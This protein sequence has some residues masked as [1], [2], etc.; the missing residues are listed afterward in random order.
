MRT[1]GLLSAFLLAAVPAASADTFQFSVNSSVLFT[2]DN[3]SNENYEGIY[4][5]L[6][7]AWGTQAGVVVGAPNGDSAPFP[8]VSFSL[9]VGS[10]IT[11]ATMEIVLPET[12]YGGTSTVF[13]TQGL[14]SDPSDPTH[15]APTFG[16]GGAW[17]LV[18]SLMDE[19]GPVGP[20][21][22]NLLIIDGNDV[23]TDLSSLWIYGGLEMAAPVATQGYNFDSYVRG[24]GQVEIPYLLEI[25]GTDTMTPEPSSILLLVTGIVGLIG[26][27]RRKN[28][29]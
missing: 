19:G 8:D 21:V 12:A 28:A 3:M 10:V 26:A 13:V 6:G 24:S 23:S 5:T 29:R 4:Y 9:P 7:D 22:S 18:N 25:G 20:D 1:L 14:S 16:P 27:I 11:S 17:G 15:I 2:A